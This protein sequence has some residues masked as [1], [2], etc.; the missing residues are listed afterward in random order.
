MSAE[1]EKPLSDQAREILREEMKIEIEKRV[2]PYLDLK[3]NPL[4]RELPAE[5]VQKL[6]TEYAAKVEDLLSGML[7]GTIKVREFTAYL[8]SI[9]E[10]EG[11]QDKQCIIFTRSNI[12]STAETTRESLLKMGDEMDEDEIEDIRFFNKIFRGEVSDSHVGF[13]KEEAFSDPD[14]GLSSGTDGAGNSGWVEE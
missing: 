7:E 5:E 8:L 9:V 3:T 6:Y 12:E 11:L 2:R 10:K 14:A 4:A 13:A 1:L